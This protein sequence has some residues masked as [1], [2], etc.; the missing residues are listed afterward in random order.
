MVVIER[1]IYISSAESKRTCKKG[2][3]GERVVRL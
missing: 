3:F 1:N 2:E